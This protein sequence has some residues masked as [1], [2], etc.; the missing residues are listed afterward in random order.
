M[1]TVMPPEGDPRWIERWRSD[2]ERSVGG[3]SRN[4]LVLPTDIWDPDHRALDEA[5]VTAMRARVMPY[6][7]AIVQEMHMLADAGADLGL[8]RKDIPVEVPAGWA[9][10]PGSPLG[11]GRRAAGALYIFTSGE[12][13]TNAAPPS[14]FAPYSPPPGTY[15]CTHETPHFLP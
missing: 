8:A 9:D 5:A 10:S 7:N 11:W 1:A 6:F 2:R 14:Q 12:L 4:T 13:C 15:K 3:G